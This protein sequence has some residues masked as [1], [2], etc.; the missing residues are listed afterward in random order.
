VTAKNVTEPDSLSAA[1]AAFQTEVPSI[2]KGNE[3]KVETRNGRN[4]TYSYADLTDVTEKVLP[5]LGKHGLA[6]SSQPTMMGEHFVLHYSLSHASGQA[7]EG[8]YPLP[9][10]HTPPQELGSAITYARRYALCAVTGV[11]PGGDDDDAASAPAAPKRTRS[12][13]V[14][15]APEPPRPEVATR[16]WAALVLEAR[17]IDALRGVHGEA[18]KAAELAR[19]LDPKFAKSL[20]AVAKFYGLPTPPETV[21]VGALIAIVKPAVAER[22]TENT[23]PAP[24]PDSEPEQTPVDDRVT[25]WPTATPGEGAPEE[26]I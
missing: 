5:L 21:T 13:K 19:V 20:A 1:L 8:V 12:P 26:L 16:D 10:P 6:W 23:A 11:A 22:E 3:A 9:D 2:K 18:E 25:D 24:E 17:T 7:I 14:E 4:Y 15:T